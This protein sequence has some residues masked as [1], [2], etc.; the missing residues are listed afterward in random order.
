MNLVRTVLWLN[1]ALMITVATKIV[2]EVGSGDLHWRFLFGCS[3]ALIVAALAGVLLHRV[4]HHST[5]SESATRTVKG[6]RPLPTVSQLKDLRARLAE[7]MSTKKERYVPIVAE[8]KLLLN[9]TKTQDPSS[10]AYRLARSQMD[11]LK[12]SYYE[13]RDAYYAAREEVDRVDQ[14]IRRAL[15]GS[16]L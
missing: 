13:S 7:H 11:I 8:W 1:I 16:R 6:S 15:E 10:E 2:G 9:V 4:R 5:L 14:Q 3:G 12:P